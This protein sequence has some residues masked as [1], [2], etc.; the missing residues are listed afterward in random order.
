MADTEVTLL[1]EQ[2]NPEPED[3]M[4]TVDDVAGTPINKKL[5]FG[6]FL[7]TYNRSTSEIAVPLSNDDLDFSF[8]HGNVKRTGAIGDA[9]TDDS[10]AIQKT[11]SVAEIS[12]GF[13]YIPAGTWQIDSSLTLTASSNVWIYGDGPNATSIKIGATSVRGFDITGLCTRCHISDLWIGAFSVLAG[14]FGIHIAGTSSALPVSELK[15]RG[16]KVQNVTTP[17]SATDLHQSSFN[18]I[19]VVSSIASAVTGVG[20]HFKGVISTFVKEIDFL[21]T[22]NFGNDNF[23]VDRDCDTVTIEDVEISGGTTGYGFRLLNTGGS[24]GPRLTRLTK[25]Y[26]E[27]CTLGGFSVEDGRDVRLEGCHAAVN[28]L[29]GFTISGGDS[30]HIQDSLAL[31]NDRH[32][33]I[34]TGGDGVSIDHCDASNNSQETDNTYDGIRVENNV[35]HVR[36]NGNRSG[37]YIL[38]TAN[39]QRW[40]LSI[41]TGTD[42]IVAG[43]NDLQGNTSGPL[44]VL[45]TGTNNEIKFAPG[46]QTLDDSGT[47]SILA[48]ELFKTG[49]ITAIT[50]FDNGFIGK[51]ITILAAHSVTIT[52]G[53]PIQLSGS[54]NFGMVAGDS[55]TLHMFND[56]VWEETSRTTTTATSEVVTTTNVIVASESGKTFYLDLAGGFTSTLPAPALGL[57][58][59]FIVKTAP[60]TAYIITTNAGANLLFGTFLDIVGELTYFSAQDTLNFVAVTSVVGDFLEVESDGTNWY[61]TA[62]SGADG[63]ITVAVT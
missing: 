29:H 35:S 6:T 7:S 5:G 52:D 16:V 62:K 22:Q 46:V 47:P 32:G 34:V 25:C 21:A 40:G 14:T 61:C 8:D 12:G 45:S 1:P 24:T 28:N 30:I 58:Y 23:R 50:D 53:A 11:I 2:T 13:V 20:I 59:T 17:I 43:N 3:L 48:G 9:A 26:A 44:L 36:V 54:V 37:D 15:I 57:K 42:F 38:T 63:G 41:G 4:H 55:L 60:T 49:G 19:H 18:R 27:E 56:Q 51:T 39:G 31:Q 10:A 33:F